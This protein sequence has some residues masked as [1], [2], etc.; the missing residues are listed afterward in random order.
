MKT[1]LML[2]AAG[3]LALAASAACAQAAPAA[4]DLPWT[5]GDKLGVAIPAN[6]HFTQGPAGM[7]HI[8][9]APGTLEHVILQNGQLRFDRPVFNA[10]RMEVTLSAPGVTTFAL[11]GSQHLDIGGYKQDHLDASISGSGDIKVRGE[12][13]QARLSISGSG[14]IDASGLA[15]RDATI[16]ISGSGNVT[17]APAEVAKVNISGSGEVRLKGRAAQ[18]ESRISGSGKVI[19]GG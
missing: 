8:T 9:G 19:Q 6:V 3:A 16:R 14:D 10:S 4:R 15:V 11:S 13:G 1:S 17:A 2:A 5:G 18:V 7:V 12:T